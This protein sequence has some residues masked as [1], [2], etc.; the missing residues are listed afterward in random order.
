MQLLIYA[1]GVVEM[2]CGAAA[3]P[4][5]A[6]VFF[7]M[8]A[9][10]ALLDRNT[11]T[12]DAVQV[13]VDIVRKNFGAILLMW[14][15]T[16]RSPPSVSSPAW[17]DF[18]CTP[19]AGCPADRWPRREGKG[20]RWG[21]G[22]HP[23]GATQSDD[24]K[25]RIATAAFVG[26]TA[27]MKTSSGRCGTPAGRGSPRSS[28]RRT[29]GRAEDI[30]ARWGPPGRR[31]ARESL[32]LDFG[33]MLTYGVLAGLHVDRAPILGHSPTPLLMVAGAVAGDAVEGVS[34]LKVLSG[35][36]IAV[37][38]SRAHRDGD[39]EPGRPLRQ[40]RF[41]VGQRGP[42]LGEP[43]GVGG[44]QPQHGRQSLARCGPV[45]PQVQCDEQRVGL[46]RGGDSGLMRA[47]ERLGRAAET[48]CR[49]GRHRAAPHWVSAAPGW[50]V[51]SAPP[52]RRCRR[53]TANRSAM[54]V[55]R[56]R[57]LILRVRTGEV[58]HL[59]GDREIRAVVEV[60]GQRDVG[61]GQCPTHRWPPCVA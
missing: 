31:T 10:T 32:W 42:A 60:H 11:S 25:V 44:P 5:L 23:P 9:V 2:L 47:V 59:C 6:V 26:Y 12:I 29:A 34:L 28:C 49:C 36:R 45:V 21:R 16:G 54:V 8:F 27:L 53:L 13:S 22:A 39:G 52:V 38:A 43:R 14:L 33:Y 24:A 18:W 56:R 48:R 51:R 15:V 57:G 3:P 41:G 58:P 4:G 20:S 55:R 61:A 50:P 37:N 40:L 7:S 35:S 46:R 30:M 1:A 17:S 19:T